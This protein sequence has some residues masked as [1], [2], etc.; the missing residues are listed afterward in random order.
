MKYTEA[1]TELMKRAIHMLESYKSKAK[2]SELK[3]Q[4][5]LAGF[6]LSGRTFKSVYPQIIEFYNQALLVEESET[7]KV[8]F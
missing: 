6:E 2:L 4:A 1:K 8:T 3:N 5:A 7:L